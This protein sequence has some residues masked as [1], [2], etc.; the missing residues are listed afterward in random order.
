MVT[1]FVMTASILALVVLGVA[2]LRVAFRVFLIVGFL[3][4]ELAL[5]ARRWARPARAQ[6]PLLG[7]RL[8]A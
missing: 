3:G 5:A 1:I 7:A 2:G 6:I 8:V 4:L